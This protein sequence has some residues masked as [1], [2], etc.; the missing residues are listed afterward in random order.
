MSTPAPVLE[1]KRELTREFMEKAMLEWRESLAL[2]HWAIRIDWDEPA[3]EDNYAEVTPKDSYDEA[4]I[5]FDAGWA[6][7]KPDFAVKIIIHE[8][9]HLTTRDMLNA[10]SSVEAVLPTSAW[11]LFDDRFEHEL[12]GV[13]ERIAV[14][15]VNISRQEGDT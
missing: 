5:R 8:L 3:N 15:L 9:L 2:T 4:R 13:I 7:W 6:S 1:F 11:K 12:E 14:T 10:A